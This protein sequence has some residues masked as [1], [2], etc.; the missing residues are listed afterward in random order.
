[1]KGGTPW[2]GARRWVRPA[3]SAPEEPAARSPP[4]AAGGGAAAEAPPLD[5]WD[6]GAGRTYYWSLATLYRWVRMS[7]GGQNPVWLRWGLEFCR[8]GALGALEATLPP[9]RRE[10]TAARHDPRACPTFALILWA[11]SG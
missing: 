2:G 3:P 6:G 10:P 11:R 5:R 9:E 8:S 7:D 1:M 4:S